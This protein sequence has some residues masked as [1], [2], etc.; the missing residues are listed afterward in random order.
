MSLSRRSL[1]W[2]AVTGTCLVLVVLA[3]SQFGGEQDAV[4]AP[5]PAATPANVASPPPDPGRNAMNP[6]LDPALRPAREAD[7]PPQSPAPS[8]SEAASPD[9][10]DAPAGLATVDMN[11][12]RAAL[13]DNLYWKQA[14]P[15]DDPRLLEEREQEKARRNDAYGKVLSGTGSDEEIRAYYD[16]RMHSSSDYVRFVDYLL[17]HYGETLT[18]QDLELLHVAK[19]MHLARI[20]ETPRR[21]QEAF[22]RKK[23]QDSA[24]EAWQAE[25]RAIEA[26][27]NAANE[28]AQTAESTDAAAP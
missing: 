9:S 20:N 12:V 27:E 17:D 13:P 5:E 14:A 19:R 11:A 23:K 3:A 28:A 16:E 22:D 6:A 15:T 24:R 1:R 4:P 8:P 25:Q 10:E 2:I 21:L 7:V 18:E 26:E